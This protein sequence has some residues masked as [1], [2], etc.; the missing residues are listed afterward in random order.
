MQLKT[1]AAILL[2]LAG[3]GGALAQQ[4]PAGGVTVVEPWARATPGGAK[5]GAAYMELKAGAA[6]ADKLVSA[7]SG[8]AEAVELHTHVMDGGVA[9]MRRVDGI[10]VPANGSVALKP[11]GYHIMLINLK[12]QLKAGEKVKLTLK[13]EKAGAVDVEASVQPIGAQGVGGGMEHGAHG[14]H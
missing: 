11:G 8:V 10:P 3:S 12:Q 5:V 7:S 2:T 13:F 6:G 14:K 4:P 1:A 9:R